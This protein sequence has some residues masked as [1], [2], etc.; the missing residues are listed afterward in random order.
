[1]YTHVAPFSHVFGEN[2]PN[3]SYQLTFDDDRDNGS[4]PNVFMTSD[5]MLL[6]FV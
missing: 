6:S 5:W 1:M 3:I 4:F 2:F